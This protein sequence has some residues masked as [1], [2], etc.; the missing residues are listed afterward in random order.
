MGK[1]KMKVA[2]LCPTLCK[3]MDY[4]ILQAK[5]ME[6]V[7][8]LSLLQG[9]FP[10]QGSKPGLP[11][12]KQILSHLSHQESLMWFLP[13]LFL[14]HFLMMGLNNCYLSHKGISDEK[15]NLKGKCADAS[16]KIKNA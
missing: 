4:G 14:I 6:W 8:L 7:V 5:I 2:Q 13:I 1:V 16:G 15:Q 9:I 11:H 10:T 12:S 3:A